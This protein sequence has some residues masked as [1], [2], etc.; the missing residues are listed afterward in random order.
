[1]VSP[2][3][4]LRGKGECI[5]DRGREWVVD[6]EDHLQSYHFVNAGFDPRR[7]CESAR[8]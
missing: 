3:H 2:F 4:D 5:V 8:R 7:E 1:M 6:M